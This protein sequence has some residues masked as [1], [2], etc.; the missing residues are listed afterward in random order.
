MTIETAKIYIEIVVN[1]R[2]SNVMQMKHKTVAPL[3]QQYLQIRSYE[4]T[5]I[6]VYI[7]TYSW[8]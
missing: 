5:Y 3:Q 6:Y 4:Y 2:K 8:V 7:N 1:E